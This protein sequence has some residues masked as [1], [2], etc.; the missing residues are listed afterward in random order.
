MEATP[1]PVP[2]DDRLCLNVSKAHE[3]L[4]TFVSTVTSEFATLAEIAHDRA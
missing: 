3:R 2:L 4:K 1:E